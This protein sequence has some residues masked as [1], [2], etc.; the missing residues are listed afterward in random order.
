MK[1]FSTKSTTKNFQIGAPEAEAESMNKS[2]I[3]LSDVFEDFLEILPELD[4]EKFI[5]TGRKGCG[6]TA[7]GERLYFLSKN[8][9]NYFVDFVRKEDIDIEK[10][11]QTSKD[12]GHEIEQEL[13]FKWIILIKF[14]KMLTTNESLQHIKGMNDLKHFIKRN[15]GYI[16]IKNFE[17]TELIKSNGFEI[18]VENFKSF[19][20]K[21]NKDWQFKGGKAPFY[22]L[23]PHLEETILSVMG[24]DMNVNKYYLIFDDL[25]IG[26]NLDN[27]SNLSTLINLIRLSKDFNNNLFGKNGIDA[28]VVI[29]LRDDISK[30]LKRTGA[31]T[32]KMFSSY[33]I[34]L[35][36]YEHDL[37]RIDENLL[38]LKKFIDKRIEF[39]FK[40]NNIALSHPK[41]PWDSLIENDSSFY[42][43]SSF[44]YV[45]GHSFY[46]PRDL[47]LFFK[48]L[49]HFEFQIPLKPQDV[50]KLLGKYSSEAIDEINNELSAFL[51]KHEIDYVFKGIRKFINVQCIKYDDFIAELSKFN[52][53]K[54]IH[55]VIELLFNYSIIGNREKGSRDVYLKYREGKEAEIRFNK[56][57]DIIIHYIVKVYLLNNIE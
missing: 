45:I 22:K 38:K 3:K 43:E 8:K 18:K 57:L 40:K 5:I 21:F 36:W 25:D 17:I 31:D 15:A 34:P 53:S 30:I 28:K 23:I 2:R 32:A 27:P 55:E 13:L 11:I 50:N 54:S 29:L 1:I 6:K 41:N 14:L 39:N 12:A 48:P 7:I 46:K 19:G 4:Y 37:F 49:S 52:F 16:D 42:K 44:K 10:I 56:D 47:I 26:I 33:E 20:S 51:N 35:I 24:A 9:P